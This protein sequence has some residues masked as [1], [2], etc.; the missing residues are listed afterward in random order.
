VVIAFSF[1]N[2]HGRFNYSWT[3]FTL[4]YWGS[5]LFAI[6]DL[7]TAMEHSIEVAA[8]ATIGATVLGT[9]VGIALGKYRFRGQGVT[10]LVQFACIAAPEVVLGSSLATFFLQLR[11]QEGAFT[12]MAAH[13]MFCMSFVAITV[14]ARVLTLDPSVE[15]AAKDLGASPWD[16]FR[17]VTLPMI[18]PGV[19]AGAMLAFALSIDD[20]ITTEFTSGSFVTYPLWIWSVSR[21]GLPPQVNVMGSIVFAVGVL[22]AVVNSVVSRR[23][24]G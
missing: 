17:L 3:G 16:T 4:K 6:P 10:N 13:V 20:F 22:F 5:K 1:N 23:R 24:A 12:V 14:R 11:I 15:D 7:T 9:L 2:P 19:V 18:M 21:Q 8:V